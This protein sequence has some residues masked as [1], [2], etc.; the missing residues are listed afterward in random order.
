MLLSVYAILRHVYKNRDREK[1]QD[2]KDYNPSRNFI[3]EFFITRYQGNKI[4]EGELGVAR[5]T[6]GEIY[7][8]K[9]SC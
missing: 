9:I 8:I 6:L 5:R 3:T 4:Q 1:P 7:K 2:N